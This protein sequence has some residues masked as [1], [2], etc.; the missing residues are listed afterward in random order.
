MRR[1]EAIQ[2]KLDH[3]SRYVFEQTRSFHLLYQGDPA[4]ALEAAD[5]RSGDPR[6]RSGRQHLGSDAADDV[7]AG[8]ALARRRRRRRGHDRRVRTRS[9]CRS[10]WSSWCGCRATR[11]RSRCCAATSS[12]PSGWRPRPRLRRD[13]SAC[14][15]D[16]FAMAEL[17]AS[18]AD[19][20]L[21]RNRLSEA[22]ARIEHLMRIV[23]NG[24]RPLLEVLCHLLFARLATTRGDDVVVEVHLDRARR[25]IPE[26]TPRSWRTSTASSCATTLRPRRR[27]SG[28]GDPRPPSAVAVETDLLAARIRLVRRRRRRRPRRARRSSRTSR[29]RACCIEHGILAALANADRDLDVAHGCSLHDALEV[30]RAMGWQQIHRRRR[31]AAVERCCVRCPTVGAIGRLRRRAARRD[32]R[33]APLARRRVDQTRPGRAV[34][35]TRAHGAALPVEP[36]RRRG[37]R[38]RAV[39]LGEHGQV[40][41]QGDLPQARTSTPAPKPFAADA[42]SA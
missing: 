30:A 32:R 31:P 27:V 7:P 8:A 25:V 18:A 13:A 29:C 3:D 19:V 2:A 34:E 40:P 6:R 24:R 42:T 37:D 28:R 20:A 39:P 4:G 5:V 1:V 38:G 21:E 11:R 12:R 17:V 36:A 15:P 22:E 16:S 23:D 9:R 14:H 41:R 26:A 33:R 35:R 10:P